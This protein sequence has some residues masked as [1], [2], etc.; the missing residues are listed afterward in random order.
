MPI[1]LAS[2]LCALRLR[3]CFLRAQQLMTVQAMM[4]NRM[5]TRP[6]GMYVPQ[7]WYCRKPECPGAAVTGPSA[8]PQN[9]D[10]N[11]TA[12]CYWRQARL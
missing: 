10:Q 9:Q 6:M 2:A 5:A 3:E 8:K 4:A 7:L 12:E 1:L 11:K